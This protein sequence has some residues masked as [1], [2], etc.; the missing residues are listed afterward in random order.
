M[1]VEFKPITPPPCLS[2]NPLANPPDRSMVFTKCPGQPPVLYA[3]EDG[4]IQ[5]VILFHLHL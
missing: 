1:N 4:F 5:A 2:P 3:Y